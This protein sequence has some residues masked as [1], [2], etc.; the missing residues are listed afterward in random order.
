MTAE[1]AAELAEMIHPKAA[2]P[3]HYGSVVG[4][5][6]E[7]SDICRYA[8]R[9][10][11]CHLKN[12]I[13]IRDLQILVDLKRNWKAYLFVYRQFRFFISQKEDRNVS[14]GREKRGGSR[15]Q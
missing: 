6:E 14:A 8:K 2:V 3:T 4:K 13:D 7:W 1:E 10:N 15:I 5:A 12:V 9:Q 11:Q